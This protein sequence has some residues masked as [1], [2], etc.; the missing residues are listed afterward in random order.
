MPLAHR[1]CRIW[2]PRSIRGRAVVL[3][4]PASG[5][6]PVSVVLGERRA[7]LPRRKIRWS[8]LHGAECLK[9]RGPFPSSIGGKAAHC[10]HR[11]RT[12]WQARQHGAVLSRDGVS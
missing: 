1:H 11:K 9:G 4:L 6:L 12:N 3:F 2:G 10:G 8:H 5:R 7:G